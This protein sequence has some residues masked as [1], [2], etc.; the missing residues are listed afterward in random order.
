VELDAD[1]PALVE[2]EAG[3]VAVGDDQGGG[4]IGHG[5]GEG[6]EGA[7]VASPTAARPP[8]RASRPA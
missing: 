6:R 3:A 8:P 5:L 1:E 4:A 7:A 2:G